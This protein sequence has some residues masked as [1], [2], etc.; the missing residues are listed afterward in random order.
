MLRIALLVFFLM[1][2]A[3][4]AEED[5]PYEI[6]MGWHSGSAVEMHAAHRINRLFSPVLY[7]NMDNLYGGARLLIVGQPNKHL[8]SYLNLLWGTNGPR[9]D[10]GFEWPAHYGTALDIKY[11]YNKGHG[12]FI[13]VTFRP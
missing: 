5:H 8:H 11:I 13:G 1:P 2:L 12:V 9:L 4:F 3:A 10:I 7:V 6:G